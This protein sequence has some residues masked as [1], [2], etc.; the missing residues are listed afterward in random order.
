MRKLREFIALVGFRRFVVL[1]VLFIVTGTIT[2]IWHFQLTP[3]NLVLMSEKSAAD[4]DRRRL[5]ADI[6]ELPDKYA[7]LV[8]NETRFDALAQKGFF[9]EQDRINARTKLDTLRSLA[10]LRGIS[11]DIRPQEKVDHPQSYA[12]NKELVR[13]SMTVEFKGLTDLEMRDF[14][15]K[16]QNDFSGLVVVEKVSFEPAD[17]LNATNLRKLSQQELVDFIR[18]DASFY[19]YSI[20][21]KA[22]NPTSPQAQAF[23][24]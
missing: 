17:E 12:L 16:M 8:A 5:Q 21:D 2:A 22:V 9:A 7:K 15:K 1:V 11:Y 23:G 19:W 4:N 20:I 10:G 13:S 14:I 24:G 3:Q 6:R 18:G